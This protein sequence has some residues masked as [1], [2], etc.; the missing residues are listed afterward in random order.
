MDWFRKVDHKEYK[1]ALNSDTTQ[2]LKCVKKLPIINTKYIR[3]YFDSSGK[4]IMFL[5]EDYHWDGVSGGIKHSKKNMRAG[6]I[7]DAGT[8]LYE[9]GL[10]G[11]KELYQ[12]H[13]EFRIILILN[14]TNIIWAWIMYLALFI[15]SIPYSWYKQSRYN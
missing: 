2:V 15:F 13:S 1:Y 6:L 5:Q 10:I 7:H 14:K 4:Q 12:F 3:T 9:M 11:I 8:Q